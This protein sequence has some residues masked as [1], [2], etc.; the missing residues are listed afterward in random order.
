[1]K[2]KYQKFL[3]VFAPFERLV[4]IAIELF[5][6]Y[7]AFYLVGQYQIQTNTAFLFGVIFYMMYRPYTRTLENWRKEYEQTIRTNK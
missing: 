4:G 2:G 1:M 7:L 6:I 5:P 3:R